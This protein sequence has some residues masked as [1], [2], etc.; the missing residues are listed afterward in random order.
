MIHPCTALRDAGPAVGLG[1]F[2]TRRIPRGTVVWTRDLLDLHLPL[3]RVRALP[4][5]YRRLLDRYGFLGADGERIVCWDTGRFV[6]HACDPNVL[7]TPW[8]LEIAVRPIE[9]GEQLTNDYATLN[10]ER[11]FR[12]ACGGPGCRGRVRPGDYESMV[13]SWDERVRAALPAVLAVEQPLFPWVE[14]GRRRALRRAARCPGAMPSLATNRL[15]A[16]REDPLAFSAVGDA[17]RGAGP[18][19]VARLEPVPAS[20]RE[21]RVEPAAPSGRDA[22][23]DP[24]GQDA[25]VASVEPAPV[26]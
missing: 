19:A 1:V 25:S 8:Q 23:V 2:A 3:D 5:R 15:V 6:N 9:A 10:L 20:G 24:A 18:V 12:C 16:A 4:L 11:G 26:R 22:R 14:A 17:R 7:P 13:A 21:A